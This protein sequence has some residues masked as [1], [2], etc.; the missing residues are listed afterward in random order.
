MITILGAQGTIKNVDSFIQQLLQFSNEEHLVIQAFDATV[1]YSKDHL[2]SAATHAKRAFLQGTNATNSL[3]LEIL[4]YAAGER[5]IQKAIKKVGVKKGEQQIVFLITDSADRK[6]KK[7]I[8]KAVIRRILKTFQ[9]TTDEQELK[10]D[11]ET[12]KRFGIT[13][14]E[15]STIPEEKYGDLILEK[16]ALVDVIK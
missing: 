6:G 11:G 7:S 12:L 13:E 4:L 9:L 14:I 5:Q 15:L 10:A 1:I 3:A 2:I 16:I 8:D